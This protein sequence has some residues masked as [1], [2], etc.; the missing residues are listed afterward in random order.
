MSEK[1][2]NPPPAKVKRRTAPSYKPRTP[3]GKKLWEIRKRIVASG[4]PLLGWDDIRALK[5]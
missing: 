1:R 3:L 2:K 5:D 4:E